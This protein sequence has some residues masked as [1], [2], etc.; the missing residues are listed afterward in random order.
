MDPKFSVRRGNVVHAVAACLAPLLA[1]VSIAH[2]ETDPPED[3]P[4]SD[5][6]DATAKGHTVNVSFDRTK[7]VVTSR[8]CAASPCLLDRETTET[9][10]G[11]P[12]GA[13][14]T[15]APTSFGSVDVKRVDLEG[16]A[17]VV[18]V[19]AKESGATGRTWEAL[20]APSHAQ[21]LF[22]GRTGLGDGDPGEREGVR[23]T[24]P[25]AKGP[26]RL[27]VATIREGVTICGDR[28]SP[29]A[30]RGLDPVSGTLKD[31]TIS[32][33]APSRRGGATAVNATVVTY[34]RPVASLLG[35]VGSSSSPAAPVAAV[36]G[37][38]RTAWSESRSGDGRGEFVTFR[39]PKEV[40]LTSVDFRF[41][42][43]GAGERAASPRH[44]LVVDETD[45][46]H[47]AIPEG[48]AKAGTAVRFSFPSP[49]RTACLSVVLDDA[50][51]EADRP[52]VSIAEVSARTRFDDA[53][54]R[55]D[56]FDRVL[57]DLDAPEGE[58]EASREARRSEALAV[59]VRSG[60]TGASALASRFESLGPKVQERVLPFVLSTADCAHVASVAARRMDASE[61]RVRTAARTRLSACGAEAMPALG[62]LLAS[63]GAGGPPA[64][65]SS[66]R[67]RKSVRDALEAAAR[68]APAPSL[69]AVYA[70]AT[71]DTAKVDVLRAF[72]ARL[73]DVKELAAE[74]ERLSDD[75]APLRARYLLLDPL[76]RVAT[77]RPG[78]RALLERRAT[79]DAHDGVRTEATRVLFAAGAIREK[80]ARRA[81]SD[82]SPRVREVPA[83]HAGTLLATKGQEDLVRT[84]ARDPW[85]FVRKAVVTSLHASDPDSRAVPVLRAAVD[86]EVPVVRAFALEALARHGRDA[87]SAMKVRER[88]EDSRED[89]GVRASAARAAGAMCD[90]GS[91]DALVR[92][93]VD[94]ADP[95][96]DARLRIVGEASLQALGALHPDGLDRRLAPLLG[97]DTPAILK[98]RARAAIDAPGSC[99]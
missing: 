45:V 58:D 8:S 98:R 56:A 54:S 47:V 24:F 53:P 14:G 61:P 69:V 81:A 55:E 67:V 57:H 64:D 13:G 72:A 22:A 3:V 95:T 70:G 71:S 9:R 36:D 86:D 79:T 73:V 12:T 21:P 90:R 76:G 33:L 29:L 91:V 94:L 31:A 43:D 52:E 6:A 63:T 23:V 17:S 60:E 2:A 75:S 97:K 83:S 46:F 40:A 85:T 34:A 49:V 7:G 93:A 68:K 15:I 65:E 88:L 28:E 78:A 4:T 19:V 59:L 35:A 84:L 48:A 25:A 80:D 41:L 96:L 1:V 32:R 87:E 99:R 39:A 16:G 10:A 27:L 11:F 77:A 20:F 44:V 51:G 89:V 37:D 82:T 50:Y 5:H 74:A 26:K 62:A 30:V 38:P 92:V 18:H 42:P 66:A